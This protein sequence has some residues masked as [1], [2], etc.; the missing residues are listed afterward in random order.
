M[1]GLNQLYERNV[2]QFLGGH[3]KASKGIVKTLNDNSEKFGLYNN[4]ITTIVSGYSQLLSDGIITMHDPYVVNSCQITKTIWQVLDV[5]LNAGG[6]GSDS[7]VS[8]GKE[9]V[10]RGGI[11]IKI[12]RSDEAE[13]TNIT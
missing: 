1:D 3:R 4:G 7:A 13:I 9:Q 12:V 6:N 2:R 11:V 10:R 5:K 8:A